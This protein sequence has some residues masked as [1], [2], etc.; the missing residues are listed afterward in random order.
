ML[1]LLRKEVEVRFKSPEEV[2]AFMEGFEK[3]AAGEVGLGGLAA[4]AGVGILGGLAGA[5][6]IGGINRFNN[7]K[8]M[9]MLKAKFSSALQQVLNTNKIVKNGNP[10]K[11]Q[12]YADTLF[13]F[14]PHVA[15]D[16]NLLSSLLANAVLGEGVDPMTIK[17]ITD[18]EG[19]Y[20]EN[21]TSANWNMFKSIS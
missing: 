9:G 16:P 15:S 14:A 4:K 19:R 3:K 6:I 13:S 20:K 2:E 21:N 17:T 8:D 7:N 11:V 5:G 10:T 1:D 18:L 12:S